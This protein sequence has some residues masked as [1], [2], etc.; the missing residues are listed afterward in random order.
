M[1]QHVKET[2]ENLDWVRSHRD[3]EKWEDVMLIA[4]EGYDGAIAIAAEAARQVH[5]EIA[6]IAPAIMVREGTPADNFSMEER[7]DPRAHAVRLA[8]SIASALRW[9]PMPPHCEVTVSRVQRV[10]FDRRE[11]P[12]HTGVVVTVRVPDAP[13]YYIIANLEQNELHG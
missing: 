8:G 7:R 9:L 3:S 13:R 5:R 12:H 6:Y 1:I 10:S 2:R 11:P 4:S